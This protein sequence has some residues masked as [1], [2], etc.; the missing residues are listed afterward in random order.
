MPYLSNKDLPLPIRK[1]MIPKA[2]NL[3][4]RVFN[5]AWETYDH[6]KKEKRE[7][8]CFQVAWAV[9]KNNF[10]KNTEGIWS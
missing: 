9:I 4:R 10:K 5:S 3:F 7:E 1:H 6:L 8:R 2:Q